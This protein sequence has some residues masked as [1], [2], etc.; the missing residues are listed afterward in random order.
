MQK[1]TPAWVCPSVRMW[2]RVVRGYAYTLGQAVICSAPLL[3]ELVHGLLM[4][5]GQH[6]DQRVRAAERDGAASELAL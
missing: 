3:D 1:G 5:A 2:L 6:L 4:P